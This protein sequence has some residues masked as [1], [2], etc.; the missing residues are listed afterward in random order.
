MVQQDGG[1][2]PEGCI[3]MYRYDRALAPPSHRVRACL[4]LLLL[5]LWA[6]GLMAAEPYETPTERRAAE[7]LPP[8][9]VVTPNYQVQ[10]PVVADGYMDR[11]TVGSPFGT[12]EV[13]G[14]GALRKLLN[15]IGAIA[16]LREIKT[17]QAFGDAVVNTAKGPLRFAKNLITNPVD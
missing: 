5:C 16:A 17:G 4:T 9:M 8:A 13:T 10:D 11:F 1:K 2:K 12:F 6:T 15:E 3:L 14:H 7:V